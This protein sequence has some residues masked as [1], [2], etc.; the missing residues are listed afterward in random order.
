MTKERFFSSPT[1]VF[2]ACKALLSGVPIS[3]K[4]E[5]RK[6][7]GW[8]LGAILHRLRNEYDWPIAVEYRGPE[9]IAY[10]SMQPGFDRSRL[11]FPPSAKALAEEGGAQ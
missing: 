1:Q 8:R 5:I 7:N 11:R 2:G 3:H 10:Y 4:D 9:N 6:V